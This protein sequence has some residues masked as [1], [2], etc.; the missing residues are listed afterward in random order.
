MLFE[1]DRL[2]W[3]DER[4]AE[5]LEVVVMYGIGGI[6]KTQLALEYA[7]RFREHFSSIFWIDGSSE[8]AIALSIKHC[9]HAIQRHCEMTGLVESHRYRAIR[10][11]LEEYR[12]G[13]PFCGHA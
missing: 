9:L 1:L 8:D 6:G 10:Q 2:L 13:G 12:S 5:A 11:V 4:E 3:P 7:Y